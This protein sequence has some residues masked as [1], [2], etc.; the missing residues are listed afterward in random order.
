M[1]MD[2][3]LTPDRVFRTLHAGSKKR[4]IELAAQRIAEALPELN[5]S[6]V[7]RNLIERE[8]LGSTGLGNGVAIPHCRLSSC[9]KIIGSLF[10]FD[11]GIDFSSLDEIPVQIMFVLLVPESET[12]QHLATLAGLAEK[13]QDEDYRQAL[14]HA[15]DDETLYQ[16]ARQPGIGADQEIHQ[17]S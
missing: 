7:Y 16:L 10:V 1:D 13:F 11:K 9:S 3:I 6:K 17:G 12:S 14:I 4:A 8:K 2:S 5:A 15:E